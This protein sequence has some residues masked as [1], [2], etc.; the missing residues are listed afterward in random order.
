[1]QR[2]GACG[3]HSPVS[4]GCGS[5][6]THTRV[7][8]K[9][10]NQRAHSSKLSGAGDRSRR[11]KNEKLPSWATARTS[12]RRRCSASVPRPAARRPG[13]R[14]GPRTWIGRRWR[15][16]SARSRAKTLKEC[17]PSASHASPVRALP[18]PSTR[19]PGR[20]DHERLPG[21]TSRP[22][23]SELAPTPF[24]GGQSTMAAFLRSDNPL[25]FSGIA[26][27]LDSLNATR[28]SANAA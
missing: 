3:G 15:V 11:R 25:A 21:A 6:I 1:M 26:C 4:C 8:C 12:A 28:R 2:Q 10:A 17:W 19:R 9:S 13:T 14:A 23:R 20:E 5:M 7:E 16:R 24:R 18:S 27:T 22:A